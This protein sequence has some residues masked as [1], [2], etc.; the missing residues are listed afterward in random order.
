M[1]IRVNSDELVQRYKHKMPVISQ[2]ERRLI[3]SNIKSVDEAVIAETLDKVIQ[4]EA[5]RFEVIFI[6]DDWKGNERWIQTECDLQKK[7]VDVIY[8]PYT[9]G[10]CST[11]LRNETARCVDE[12]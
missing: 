3:V 8:L 2:N 11:G 5:L 4:W 6:G 1:L 9:K 7:G 12:F 10:V